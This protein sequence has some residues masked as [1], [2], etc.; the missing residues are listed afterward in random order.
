MSARVPATLS[1]HEMPQ[2]RHDP[3]LGDGVLVREMPLTHSLLVRKVH[4]LLQRAQNGQVDAG[5]PLG[6]VLPEL[7]P[8][9][10]TRLA[11]GGTSERK[12]QETRREQVHAGHCPHSREFLERR[13]ARRN[14]E[15][16]DGDNSSPGHEQSKKT[17]KALDTVQRGST[18]ESIFRRFRIT[19]KT[20]ANN[21]FFFCIRKKRHESSISTQGC[22]SMKIFSSAITMTMTMKIS[23]QIF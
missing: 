5:A 4:L 21:K 9:L 19:Q 12:F 6:L 23:F 22:E 7:S 18:I 14:N 17:N 8:Q 2:P 16:V 1:S 3:V 10:R 13:E 20:P 11:E 15:I